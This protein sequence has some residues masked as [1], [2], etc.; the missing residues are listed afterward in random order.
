MKVRMH[1]TGENANVSAKIVCYDWD[2]FV[3]RSERAKK[4]FAWENIGG[5]STINFLLLKRSSAQKKKRSL[6]L[7]MQATHDLLCTR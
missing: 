5:P 1:I 6:V 7:E 2:F 3:R 4:K